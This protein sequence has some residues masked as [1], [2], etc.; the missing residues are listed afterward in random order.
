MTEHGLCE[1]QEHKSVCPEPGAQGSAQA[2][3]APLLNLFLL[4]GSEHHARSQLWAFA[5][6]VSLPFAP[7][8]PAASSRLSL[9]LTAFPGSPPPALGSLSSLKCIYFISFCFI[10][11]CWLFKKYPELVH[12][13]SDSDS[14]YVTLV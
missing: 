11:F 8:L 7:H 1:E 10:D 9:K 6:E 12:F 2:A 5:R 14:R 13:W 4:N 3:P